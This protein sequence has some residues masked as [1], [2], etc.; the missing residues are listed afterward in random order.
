MQDISTKKE[1]G[2][3]PEEE[4]QKDL[5]YKTRNRLWKN[6]DLLSSENPRQENKYIFI[7][8]VLAI[9]GVIFYIL[10]FYW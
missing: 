9:A 8:M 2:K 10:T 7:L 4:I 3:K 1:D 6:M 5:S